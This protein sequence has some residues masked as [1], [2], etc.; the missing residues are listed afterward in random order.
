MVQ[1]LTGTV[2]AKDSVSAELKEQMQLKATM[3]VIPAADQAKLAKSRRG[4]I[5]GQKPMWWNQLVVSTGWMHKKGGMT[6]SWQR[7]FFIL[8]NTSQVEHPSFHESS[9]SLLVFSALEKFV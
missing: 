9:L 5:G 8:Y 1:T 7:R 2:D 6:K 4:S 3:D